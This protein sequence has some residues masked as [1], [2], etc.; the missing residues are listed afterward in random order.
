NRP[1]RFASNLPH[2]GLSGYNGNL[3]G[4][5][6]FV[7]LEPSIR[8]IKKIS[9]RALVALLGVLLSGCLI[10]GVP[11]SP[12]PV[13]VPPTPTAAPGL[14]SGGNRVR[15]GCEDPWYLEPTDATP[16]ITK[17]EAE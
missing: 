5:W 6:T 11:P 15:Y 1:H 9:V 17:S 12:T 2:G 3:G 10:E 14:T 13:R 7:R 16:K 4:A 8:F